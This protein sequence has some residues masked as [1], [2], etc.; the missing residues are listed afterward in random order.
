M[1]RFDDTDHEYGHRVRGT[2]V[3]V[4]RF[5]HIEMPP[6]VRQRME[7]YRAIQREAITALIEGSMGVRSAAPNSGAHN[8]DQ[9]PPDSSNE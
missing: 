1:G 9:Q 3:P 7:E 8:P 2:P 5:V 4:V 6:E